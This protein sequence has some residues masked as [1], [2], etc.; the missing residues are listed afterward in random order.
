MA[1]PSPVIASLSW[2]PSRTALVLRDSSFDKL[3]PALF[4]SLR[5]HVFGVLQSQSMYRAPQIHGWRARRTG[6][7]I[8]LERRRRPHLT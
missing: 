1:A 7:R 6:Q 2:M 5:S 3:L 4:Q 8:R